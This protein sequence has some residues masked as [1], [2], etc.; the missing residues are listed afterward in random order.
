[1]I[2][3]SCLLSRLRERVEEKASSITEPRLDEASQ[4][5]VR[6]LHLLWVRWDGSELRKD[7]W[8]DSGK[9]V[10]LATQLAANGLGG[11]QV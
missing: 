10:S 9:T 2:R 5:L 3:E 6:A 11:K 7:T 4:E 1:M 8:T